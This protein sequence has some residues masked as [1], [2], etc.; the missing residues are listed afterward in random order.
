[1]GSFQESSIGQSG[2][3]KESTFIP[4][5]FITSPSHIRSSQ[6]NSSHVSPTKI[7][8][9]QISTDQFSPNQLRTTQIGISEE[10]FSQ[11]SES[12]L[13]S[14]QFSTTKSTGTHIIGTEVSPTEIPVG[15]V[16]SSNNLSDRIIL[17]PTSSPAQVGINKFNS[18]EVSLS[19]SIASE[20]LISSNFY[21]ST[22]QIINRLN[23]SA[24]NIWADLLQ[25]EIQL[26]IDFQIADLPKGQLAEVTITDFDDS[27]KP[28]AGTILI[29]HDAN[30]VGWFI[31][32]TPLNNSEFTAQ[33]T[34]VL[35]KSRVGIERY[36]EGK[37]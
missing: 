32:E 22:P 21:N 3:T 19:N 23:N 17:F 11:V 33:N 10:S 9:P 26:D 30:G 2:V 35:A 28:N 34:A 13:T 7:G 5:S 4:S 6:I 36:V 18:E 31:D 37:D 25:S 1:M 15:K 20:E 16:D 8:I 29:D 12:K 14:N 27:G 24:T